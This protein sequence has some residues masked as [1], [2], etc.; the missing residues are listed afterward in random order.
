MSNIK[1]IMEIMRKEEMINVDIMKDFFPEC[2]NEDDYK[3]TNTLV[4][5]GRWVRSKD[6]MRT[7]TS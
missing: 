4:P 6:T 5:G 3:L 1:K 7:I 2:V